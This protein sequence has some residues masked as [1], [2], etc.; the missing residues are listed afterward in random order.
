MKIAIPTRANA[1]DNHFGHCESYSIFTIGEN[2][3]IESTEKLASPQGCGCKS[4]IASVLQDK[5]VTIMLAGN[6]GTGALNILTKHGIKVYRGCSGNVTG[7][8]NDFLDGKVTDSG[9]GCNHHE[10]GHQCEHH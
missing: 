4:N 5:D 9:E 2:K 10:E 8:I 6:M 3:N 7:L 1:V